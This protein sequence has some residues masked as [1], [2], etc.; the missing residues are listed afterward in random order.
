MSQIFP[1]VL[2]QNGV[3]AKTWTSGER[4]DTAHGGSEKPSLAPLHASRHKTL[5]YAT[6]ALQDLTTTQCPA[7]SELRTAPQTHSF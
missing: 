3:P 7:S 2:H 6:G 5:N 4:P 1:T